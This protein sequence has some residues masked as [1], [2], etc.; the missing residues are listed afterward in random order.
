M[1]PQTFWV[2]QILYK[3]DIMLIKT[4]ICFMYMRIFPNPE[5]R[6][7]SW[8]VVAFVNMYG[9]ANLV[10]TVLQCTPIERI[11]NK[12]LDGTCINLT[13]FWYTNAAANMLSDFV[14]LALPIPAVKSLNLPQRQKLG[15][16]LVF[17]LGG[18]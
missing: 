14:I 16:M 11:W 4:S 8:I 15:L 13:A 5:F 12:Q 7:I 1:S 3:F 10:A 17:A 18:L 2:A 9:I 6:R